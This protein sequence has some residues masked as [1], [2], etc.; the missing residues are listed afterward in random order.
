MPLAPG[1]NPLAS[2]P[3][4]RAALTVTPV[5]PY[6]AL[7][8]RQL[9]GGRKTRN[10]FVISWKSMTKFHFHRVDV[11]RG[12]LIID[13]SQ[14]FVFC[15]NRWLSLCGQVSS[16]HSLRLVMSEHVPPRR[17]LPDTSP[18]HNADQWA[19]DWIC[20]SNHVFRNTQCCLFQ[21]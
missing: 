8:R 7:G 13:S 10:M 4:H 16:H 6:G 3:N 14:R 12:N 5:S 18:V 2:R 20:W 11:L 17:V 15:V 1:Q 21:G 19:E 9:G